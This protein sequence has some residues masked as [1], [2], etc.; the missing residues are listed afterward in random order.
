MSREYTPLVS[1]PLVPGAHLPEPQR[2]AGR[3][4]FDSPALD[5][6]TDFTIV[7]AATIEPSATVKEANLSMIRRAVRSLLVTDPDR[8]VVGI[9][10]AT[11]LLGE[12]PVRVALELKIAHTEVLVRDVM[13]PT[14][15]LEVLRFE[16]V[17]SAKIGHVAA[18]L[19]HAGRQHTL[20]VQTGPDG[21]TVRGIFSLT[22]IA[23]ALGIALQA[24][25]IATTFADVEAALR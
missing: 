24:P 9:I 12:R 15:R 5:L 7:P 20:V 16:D 22:H 3:S 4:G 18:A 2:H 21:D 19:A 10:T 17:E 25:E 23:A 1:H 11:D 8:R 13:T 6:M 14:E